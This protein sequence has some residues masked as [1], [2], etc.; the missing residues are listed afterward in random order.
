MYGND[1]S[2]ARDILTAMTNQDD[3]RFWTSF[4]ND[5][6]ILNIIGAEVM[7]ISLNE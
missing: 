6:F 7:K 1:M 4:I 5:H 2:R 3:S